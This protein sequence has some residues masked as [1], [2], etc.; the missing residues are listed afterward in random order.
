MRLMLPT[1]GLGALAA[2]IATPAGAQQ[3]ISTAI[4]TPVTTSGQDVTIDTTGSV[5][6][7][8]GA[9]VTINSSNSVTNKGTIGITG[10]N[11]ATGILANT[12]LA[13]TITNSGTIT[14]N[15]NYTPTATESDSNNDG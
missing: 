15:E 6:P 4:T 11:N 9:A 7:S 12:N 14:I 13:G 5:K 2:M 1:T 10:A 8:G 3:V